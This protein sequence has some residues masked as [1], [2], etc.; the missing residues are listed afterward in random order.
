MNLAELDLKSAPL[1]GAKEKVLIEKML[2][3][4]KETT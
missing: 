3:Q 1:T 4:S 2:K